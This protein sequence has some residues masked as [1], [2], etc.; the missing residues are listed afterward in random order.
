MRPGRPCAASRRASAPLP[1]DHSLQRLLKHNVRKLVKRAQ[2]A[3][4]L[5][6]VAQDDEYPL[7][8]R[9]AVFRA[10]TA[11]WVR[12]GGG[13]LSSSSASEAV[14]VRFSA[15]MPR[16]VRGARHVAHSRAQNAGSAPPR[17][18][19]GL[20]G[21]AASPLPPRNLATS[22]QHVKLRIAP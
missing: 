6:P 3:D 8:A 9:R 11:K 4:D 21:G 19:I 18:G 15:S 13:A 12:A 14:P 1:H 22:Q 10:A 7:C 2:R 5:A 16:K 20:I 17:R